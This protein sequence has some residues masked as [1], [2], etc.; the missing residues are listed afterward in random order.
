MSRSLLQIVLRLAL[1][2]AVAWTAWRCFGLTAMVTT[3]PLFG[4]ALARP[5]LDLASDLR[6]HAR[7]RALDRVQGHHYAFRGIPVQVIE[8]LQHERWVRA[9]DVRRILGH[10]A[11]DGALALSY[12]QG[13][14]QLGNPPQPHFSTAALI[15]HLAKETTPEALRLRHWVEREVAFPARRRRELLGIRAEPPDTDPAA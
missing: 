11:S 3:A 6:H 2:T 12:P 8:D 15:A 13:W 9:A 5:L 1:C 4:V 7:A 10:T 14:R